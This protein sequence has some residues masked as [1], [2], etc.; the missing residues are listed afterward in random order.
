VQPRLL[1]LTERY[2]PDAGGVAV[3]AH[4]IA[5]ALAALGNQIDVLCW[6][7]AL[8]AGVVVQGDGN[9]AV[10]RQGRFREWESTLPHTLNLLDWL[11]SRHRYQAIW[12]H[13][14]N[15]AGFVAA[16]F[17]KQNGIPS[18]ASIRGNDLDREMFPL[19]DFARLEWT[20]RNANV[21]TSVTRAL[22]AKAG[23][24]SGR[25]DIALL[26]NVVDCAIFRPL[27]DDLT[28]LRKTLGIGDQE[29]VLGFSGELREKKGLQP[30]LEALRQVQAR[31]P[32]CLLVIG[33]VRPSEMQ[34]LLM[35]LDADALSERRIVVTGQLS[36][37][38]DVNRHLQLCDVY[39][40]PSL[41]DGM[42]NALLEA[43]AAGCACI[44]SDA[45]GIPEMLAP[46]VEGILLPRWQLHR[47]GE[48]VLAWLDSDPATQRRIRQAA[49]DRMLASFHAEGERRAL[50]PVLDRISSS[51]SFT[52]D[53]PARSQLK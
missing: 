28:A 12:G 7:R 34:R 49:R 36:D 32:A 14:L 45:G 15:P 25:S 43:M 41:W 35:L 47:L 27:D 44:V 53:A 8:E 31:R 5:R 1:F 21:V 18:I 23:T 3:S 46:G 24:I 40:Q 10:F 26:H 51:Y 19:G 9:P 38:A 52:S 39:L 22:A 29:A 42:P 16:F 2:L 6:T 11:L 17:G 13:Y 4:R 30:L 50:Q 33:E 37:P 48:A 20:L